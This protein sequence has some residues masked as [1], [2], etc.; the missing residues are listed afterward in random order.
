ME[1]STLNIEKKI[2][3]SGQ[4]SAG[5]VGVGGEGAC[6]RGLICRHLLPDSAAAVSL[7]MQQ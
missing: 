2:G 3:V 1:D 7:G 5:S 6:A 4:I